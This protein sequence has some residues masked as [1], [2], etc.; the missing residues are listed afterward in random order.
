MI[1]MTTL[2][3]KK[4]DGCYP[5]C[6]ITLGYSDNAEEVTERRAEEKVE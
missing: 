5:Q 2:R 6:L 3:D 4:D 1:K